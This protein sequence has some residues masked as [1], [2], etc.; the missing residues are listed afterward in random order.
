M[1]GN[2]GRSD[3]NPPEK[4]GTRETSADYN[5]DDVFVQLE[6]LEETVTSDAERKE[7][8]RTR[9]MLKRVPGSDKIRKYTTRDIG[10]SFVGGIVFALPLLVED[11]VFEI[12]EWFVE[13]TV[14]GIPVFLVVNILFILL[15]TIG[16]LYAVDFREVK[17]TNPIFGL[18][19]RRLV[20][21]LAI[22][23]IV[24]AGTMFMWGRLAAPNEGVDPS[25]LEQFAR[26]TVIWAAAALGAVLADIL[27]GESKG[28]D[29]SELI[30][31]SE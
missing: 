15:L 3:G 11:G 31:D 20:A 17:I 6:R 26:I 2:E 24:A 22:S 16:L 14:G 5:I 1:S 19:P 13:V 7:V 23:F 12:A 8:E 18:V 27:P 30:S 10:E 9:R 28:E 25:T 21:V 29:I 4:G